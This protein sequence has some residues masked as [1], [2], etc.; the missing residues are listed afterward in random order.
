M[1]LPSH[2]QPRDAPACADGIPLGLLWAL[3]VP[4]LLLLQGRAPRSAS[5]RTAPGLRATRVA[6]PRDV[7]AQEQ[8]DR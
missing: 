4:L 3:T 8:D 7:S 2:T 6:T 1:R 5:A